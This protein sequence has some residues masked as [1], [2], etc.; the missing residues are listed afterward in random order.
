MTD[1]AEPSHPMAWLVKSE[2]NNSVFNTH[3]NIL[4]TNYKN[5][6]SNVFLFLWSIIENSFVSIINTEHLQDSY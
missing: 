2:K 3:I 4:D 1:Q 5:I 6:L